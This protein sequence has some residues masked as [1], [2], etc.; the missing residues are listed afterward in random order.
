MPSSSSNSGFLVMHG[1]YFGL[2]WIII[3]SRSGGVV[4]RIIDVEGRRICCLMD[5]FT[6]VR[7][8]DDATPVRP[9]ITQ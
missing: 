8:Y 2:F 5:R 1:S 3:D 4:S 9:S 6:A 7:R